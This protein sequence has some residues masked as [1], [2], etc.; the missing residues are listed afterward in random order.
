[1]IR[2]FVELPSFRKAWKEMGLGDEDLLKLESLLLM[3]PDKGELIQGT[4]GL[5]KVR[6]ALP[7][8]GKRG[9]A[10]VVYVDFVQWGKL[11]LISAYA[12]NTQDDLSQDQKKNIRRLIRIL[13]MELK[14]GG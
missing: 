3:A 12:K 8:R 6:W 1:M 2:E 11:Y 10:R 14:K 7:H 13:S 4:G 9:S 5:R